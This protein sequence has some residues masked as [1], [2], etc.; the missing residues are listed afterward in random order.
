MTSSRSWRSEE[1]A[2]NDRALLRAAREVLAVD[3]AHASV[4]SIAA[5]AGLGV[6]SLYR[7]YRTKEELFKRLCLIALREYLD[8]ATEGLAMDDPWEG[9]MHY[10]MASIRSGPAS[11]ASVAGTFELTDE[12]IELAGQSDRAVSRLVERAHQAK[13]LRAGVTPVDLELLIEQLSKSPLQEQLQRQGRTELDDAARNARQR[14]ITIALDGLRAVPA[15]PV[16]GR[17]PGY[18]LFAVRWAPSADGA[19]PPE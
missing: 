3:G 2:R 11:L 13:V 14:V 19:Q 8:A 16:P 18:E 1:V 12:M 15:G 4:A 10:A 17:P 7:R 9:V 6:G 5:R